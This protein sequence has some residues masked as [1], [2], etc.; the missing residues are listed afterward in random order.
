MTYVLTELDN[1][2]LGIVWRAG[3]ITAYGVRN[4][5]AQSATLTWSAS[6]GS[7]YPS[8][9]RLRTARLLAAKPPSGPRKSELLHL[10][11]SGLAALELW[12]VQTDADFGRATS[13]PIRTRI[14]FLGALS[15]GSR[16]HILKHYQDIT[17]TAIDELEQRLALAMTS[18]IDLSEKLGVMGALAELRARLNWLI[19]VEQ[20]LGFGSA[21]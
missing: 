2:I 20:V 5:F 3:S 9:R 19:E 17:R 1:C 8:I 11:A 16:R 15:N 14:H 12:L 10:T 6:T 4:Y 7:V 13:D 18:E 21:G